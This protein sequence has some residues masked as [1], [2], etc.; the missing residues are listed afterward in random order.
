V[1]GFLIVLVDF[2]GRTAAGVHADDAGRTWRLSV[3]LYA[4]TW[5]ALLT[6][7]QPRVSPAPMRKLARASF[8]VYLLH[9][10]VINASK[11]LGFDHPI[12]HV[13]L[14]VILSWGIALSLLFVARRVSL[15]GFL[16]GEGERM[17]EP[18]TVPVENGQAEPG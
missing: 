2:L 10:F 4:L 13:I 8:L 5:L 1:V 12:P 16:T 14:V 9:P 7:I 6:S 3:A 11:D 18:R 17:I 15:I